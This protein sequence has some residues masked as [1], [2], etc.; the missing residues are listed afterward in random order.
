MKVFS[1]VADVGEP[2][3]AQVDRC[4]GTFDRGIPGGVQ[5]FFVGFDQVGGSSL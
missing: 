4:F 3:L 5:K 1:E 2:T